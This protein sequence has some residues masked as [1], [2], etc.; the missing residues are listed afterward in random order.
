[1]VKIINGNLLDFPSDINVIA[2]SCNCRMI[3]GGGIAKQIK[4]RYPQAYQ[5]DVDYISD[6][7][8]HNGQFKHPLGTF[9]KAEVGD[10]KYIYNMYTQA[11]IGTGERQVDYEKFWRALKK[12]EEE[13]FEINVT[14]HEYNPSPPPILGLPWG[15]SCGLA[16]GSW[17]IVFA[18]INDI[19]L[20][21]QIKCYI[22]KYDE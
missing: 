18:M 7:Y 9:S 19:F 17:G 16:G 20:D 11:T 21:S 2:H 3:M 8:D 14:K 1:M 10:G 6:E 4:D 5:A 15:I 13:L 22:V 12:V